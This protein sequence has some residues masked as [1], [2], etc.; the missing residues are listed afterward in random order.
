M[1][2]MG[3]VHES[4]RPLSNT[5]KRKSIFEPSKFPEPTPNKTPSNE[6]TDLSGYRQPQ[7]GEM[8]ANVAEDAKIAYAFPELRCTFGG[9]SIIPD[10]AIYKWERIRF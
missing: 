3:K 1:A 4:F 7:S 10:I 9:R 5:A 6:T 2:N 8:M